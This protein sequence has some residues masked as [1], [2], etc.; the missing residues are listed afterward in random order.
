MQLKIRLKRYFYQYD[1][2]VMTKFI[3]FLLILFLIMFDQV[4]KFYVVKN[5]PKDVERNFLPGFI[6]L[7][8]VINYGSAFGLNQHQT[9]SLVTIAFLIAFVL[10]A[11]WVFSR[12]T[13]NI[14]AVSFIFAGTI[15]NLV[16]RFGN[17]GGVIDFLKWDM[18][19]PK[20]IFNL[21]D[22]MVTIGIIILVIH[23]IVEAVIVLVE[24]QKYKKGHKKPH[25]K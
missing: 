20:T 19:N 15:G 12:S 8:Y 14:I 4:V 21:A 13:T 25:G 16:D 9:A 22:V 18:F 23:W 17:D 2:Q 1:W 10:L 3:A 6:N 5:L 7:K 24:N 11:W